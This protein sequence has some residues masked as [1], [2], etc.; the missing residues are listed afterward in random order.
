M[1]KK[2]WKQPNE[3]LWMTIFTIGFFM[4][5]ADSIA[6]VLFS[7]ALMGFSIWKLRDIDL[8]DVL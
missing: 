3:T 1:N 4:M 2:K 7:F 5:C 8:E 6:I